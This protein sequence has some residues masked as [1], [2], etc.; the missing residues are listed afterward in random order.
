MAKPWDGPGE[1]VL[2][3]LIG[4]LLLCVVVVMGGGRG[5][6]AENQDRLGLGHGMGDII[7]CM[8]MYV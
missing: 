6:T 4:I 5:A 3:V 7:N 2:Q 1:L 8:E